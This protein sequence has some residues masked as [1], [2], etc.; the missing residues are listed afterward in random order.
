MIT[1]GKRIPDPS[2]EEILTDER[3]LSAFKD[4]LSEALAEENLNFWIEMENTKNE[5]LSE[6]D[7]LR[8]FANYFD[9]DSP[10]Q[11]NI[12]HRASTAMHKQLQKS[13]SDRSAFAIVQ[14]DVL[15]NMRNDLYPRFLQSDHY[16]LCINP[17]K[18]PRPAGF[19]GSIQGFMDRKINSLPDLNKLKTNHSR[20]SPISSS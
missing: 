11:I 9:T 15:D 16:K 5:P 12:S 7:K 14:E 8:I 10:A 4:F 20:Q 3:L 1:N 6:E 17:P 13:P 18:S 2:L 19:W